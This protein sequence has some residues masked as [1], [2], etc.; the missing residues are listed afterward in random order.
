MPQIIKR[1]PFDVLQRS[2]K[3]LILPAKRGQELYNPVRDT[4]VKNSKLN[5]LNIQKQIDKFNNTLEHNFYL[6]YIYHE[7][8]AR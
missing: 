8:N 6:N 5:R 2:K 3:V 7:V 4:Y 1:D